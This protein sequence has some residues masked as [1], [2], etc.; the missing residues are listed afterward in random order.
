MM[1]RSI[2]A[3]LAV[4]LLTLPLLASD[5]PQWRG[6]DRTDISKETG[7]LKS[8]PEGGPK[9]IWEA[10]GA[11]RGYA[12]VAI[13]KGKLY[14]LGDEPSSAK[15]KDE[16]LSCF[17]DATGKLLWQ[18]RL[19]PAWNSGQ[20]SWQSSRSTPTVD[21]ERV[22]VL[23]PHGVLHC[24]DSSTGKPRWKKDLKAFG[25]QK[26]DGWGYS[27]SVLVDGD[28][29]VCTPGGPKKTMLALNKMTGDVIWTAASPDDRGAS[30]SSIVISEVGDTRVYVQATGS[31]P[32]GVRAKD[33]KVLWTY[34]VPKITAVIPTPIV[35]GDLVF[36]VAGYAGGGALLKQV[37]DPSGDIKIEGIYGI[38]TALKNKHG[39]VVLVGDYLYGDQDDSGRPY[40]AELMTGNV[41]WKASRPSGSGSASMTAAD[42]HLYIH[43]ANGMAVLADASPSAYKETGS[44]KVPGSGDRPSWS[45][46][47][48]ANGRLYVREQDRINCYNVKATQ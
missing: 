11:G 45:H 30:H 16:Y 28:K 18:T 25:G 14:T 47:V 4:S 26:A 22:Y 48:V 42:G 5:W 6:P 21:D 10:K 43:Y 12:S 34:A 33:G 37:P 40:C 32:L 35:R 20:S 2:P 8:W 1:L 7:L 44:F 46:P 38:K 39:G 31:G 17:N 15:D 19:G 24:L 13:V 29:V 41:R 36:F 3:V 23:T 27:E 9:L